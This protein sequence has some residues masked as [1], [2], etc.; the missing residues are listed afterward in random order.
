M[1]QSDAMFTSSVQQTWVFMARNNNLPSKVPSKVPS[2][3]I[4]DT[5]SLLTRW[6]KDRGSLS[7]SPSSFETV[8]QLPSGRLPNSLLP[9]LTLIRSTTFSPI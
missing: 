9:S 7:A 5:H 1:V 8:L 4:N 3:Y 2:Y 6:R